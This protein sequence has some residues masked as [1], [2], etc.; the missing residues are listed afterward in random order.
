M[1][2]CRWAYKHTGFKYSHKK[3]SLN[4]IQHSFYLWDNSYLTA[5]FFPINIYRLLVN[6]AHIRCHCSVFTPRAQ[7][8]LIRRRLASANVCF[9]NIASVTVFTL[10]IHVPKPVPLLTWKH[11]FISAHLT[12]Y[13]SVSS[14]K[15]QNSLH[16]EA[17]AVG[18][19][20]TAGQTNVKQQKKNQI[21][22]CAV[23]TCTRHCVKCNKWNNKSMKIRP[24][25]FLNKFHLLSYIFLD[26]SSHDSLWLVL[27][28]LCHPIKKEKDPGN[29]SASHS[30]NWKERFMGHKEGSHCSLRWV[31]AWLSPSPTGLNDTHLPA[32][33][34]WWSF[35]SF[36]LLLC[37]PE[38]T[39]PKWLWCQDTLLFLLWCFKYFFT[40][41]K[42]W[43]L[44]FLWRGYSCS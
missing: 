8:S 41:L 34:M 10:L 11:F 6:D 32:F 7:F 17:G 3:T 27:L 44:N 36:F 12:S 25:F 13:R 4:C 18:D 37:L 35:I 39:K 19:D 28:P 42:H 26:R 33:V 31:T 29:A 15:D 1:F 2:K 14:F 9:H 22:F 38:S 23:V 24:N 30:E 43:C 21:K 20:V 5:H 40:V 16:L